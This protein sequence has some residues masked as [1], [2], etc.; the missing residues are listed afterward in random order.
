MDFADLHRFYIPP[1]VVFILRLRIKLWR[2]KMAWQAKM[3]EQDGRINARDARD[4]MDLGTTNAV[5]QRHMSKTG[6]SADGCCR[7]NSNA[8]GC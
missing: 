1:A 2:H 4:A 5:P 3:H 6:K 8:L 7:F